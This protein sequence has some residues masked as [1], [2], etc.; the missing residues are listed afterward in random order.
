MKTGS[1]KTRVRVEVNLMR[2]VHLEVEHD[3][4][5]DPLDL[6]EDER[7]EAIWDAE[8]LDAED[9]GGEIVRVT[10]SPTESAETRTLQPPTGDGE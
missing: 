7:M 5:E 8:G 10:L 6:T 2:V 1:M 4:S 9:M 3:K